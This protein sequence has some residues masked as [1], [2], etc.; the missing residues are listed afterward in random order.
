LWL[1]LV[2]L[3][4]AIFVNLAPAGAQDVEPLASRV[5]KWSDAEQAE[6]VKSYLRNG[7][8][9]PTDTL[10]VLVVSRSSFVLPLLEK[11]IEENLP[12]RSD[13][14]QRIVGGAASMIEYAGDEQSLREASKLMKLDE[15]RFGGM[16]SSALLHAG[17]RHNPFPLAYK[18]FE[19]GDPEV[20]KR[21]LEWGGND[22]RAKRVRPEGE[23]AV[24]GRS[25]GG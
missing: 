8:S 21:I 22:L 9:V 18:G 3:T 5:L 23:A 4:L 19:I 13:N 6:W 15:R 1:E 24:V 16:V 11:A 20:D 7:S 17:A 10:A 25:A 12:S 2:F 14:G